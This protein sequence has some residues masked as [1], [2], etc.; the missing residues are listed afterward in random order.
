MLTVSDLREACEY[1]E[2][3]WGSDS[4]VAIQIRNDNG[5]LIGGGYLMDIFRSND[6]T[7]FLSSHEFKQGSCE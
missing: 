3:E 7:L 6:G 5:S 4:K 1:I 2:R